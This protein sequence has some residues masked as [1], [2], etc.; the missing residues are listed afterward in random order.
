[1]L[2]EQVPVC[3]VIIQ[4]DIVY[5]WVVVVIGLLRVV[6]DICVVIVGDGTVINTSQRIDIRCC[7]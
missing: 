7:R 2:V 3:K 1:M 5:D 6:Y 4:Y